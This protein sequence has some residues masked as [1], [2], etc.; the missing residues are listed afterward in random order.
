MSADEKDSEILEGQEDDDQAQE[1]TTLKD[2]DVD[3]EIETDDEEE[4]DTVLNLSSQ[5]LDGIPEQ[6]AKAKGDTVY[7]LILTKNNIKSLKHLEY[8][9]HLETLQLDNNKLETLDDLP[10]MTHLKTLWLNNNSLADLN[11]LLKVLL[12]RC[13]RLSYL[14]LLRNPVCPS[15]YFDH[16][17]ES[18]YKRYRYTMLYTLKGLTYLDTTEVTK[19]E[20]KEAEARGKFLVVKKPD[21][22]DGAEAPEGEAVAPEPESVDVTPYQHAE[23]AA[24]LGKGRIK[25]DGRESEGNRFILNND[26]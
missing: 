20:R 21:E 15:V 19:D 11:G 2:K 17:N 22:N 24:F 16:G 4:N 23:P 1:K 26:L 3:M 18:R 6:V 7:T 12:K 14:S 10:K 13:P 5:N 8:F 9:P 25:Y